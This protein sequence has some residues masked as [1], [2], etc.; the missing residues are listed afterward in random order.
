MTKSERG[1]TLV[2]MLVSLALLGLAATM[3]ATGFA[4]AT[5][6]TRSNEARTVAGETVAAAQ[7]GLRD[8]IE[9]LRPATRFDG[10][11]LAADF[12]GGPA[13]MTFVA[14]PPI[15]ERPSPQ[16]RFH[17]EIDENGG[18]VLGD[19]QAA[20]LSGVADLRLAYFGPDATGVP[21]WT[22]D[23]S[24]RPT[25]PEAIR[26]DVTFAPGDRRRWP[27]MIVRPATTVDTTCVLDT[28]T[29]K[30]RGRS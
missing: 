6:L 4:S 19:G 10:A 24:A 21:H 20:L 16:R 3:M 13:S 7:S 14:L 12:E 28:N 23:W 1:F 22:D 8:R 2:E 25:A 18:L 30:C 26:I 15:S 11:A 5:R 29:G 27:E 17:L 9:R